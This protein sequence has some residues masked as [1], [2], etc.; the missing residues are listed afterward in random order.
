MTLP[1]W[2]LIRRSLLMSPFGLALVPPAQAADPDVAIIGAG[3]AG[4]AAARALMAAGKSVQVIEARARTGGRAFTDST[5]FGFAFDHGAQWIEAGKI[6]P[7]MAIV[8]EAA[9]KAILDQSEQAICVAGKELSK[10]DYERFEKIAH[11]ATRKIAEALKNQPDVAVGR[12]LVAQDPLERLAYA[13][14]GPLEQGV[15]NGELSARDFTR[16][17]EAEP[18]YAIAEGMGAMIARWGT[19]VPVKFDARVVR[20]DST[21]AQVTIETTAGQ[22]RARAAIVTLPT[23]VLA[24]GKIGF[25]PQLS[26][27]KRE[28][29]AQLPMASFNKVAILFARRVIDAPAGRNV[30]ALTRKELAFDA[31]VRPANREAALVFVGG[32]LARALEEEG[33][34]AAVTFA[35][36]ALAEIYGNDLRGAVAKSHATQ[37]G[38]DPYA[39]GSWSVARPGH[40]DKR[41]VLAQPHHDRV[42]FAGEA[43]DPVWATRVGGAYASGLRAAKEALAVLGGKR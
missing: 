21:G 39:T 4:L 10:E 28:A 24:T 6:N 7:A 18:Q 1:R 23:G 2:F 9:A 22:M 14:V 15:E 34:R 36:S 27:A 19:K 41:A 8:R 12:L 5:T 33:G 11:E 17:P 25:A 13:M 30:T 32:A 3:V 20:V 26:A 16:Q 42:F 35:V 38:R 43:T 37:W 29:I 40:A 31:I